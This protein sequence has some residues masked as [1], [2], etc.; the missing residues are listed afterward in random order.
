MLSLKLLLVPV[1]NGNNT[2]KM[3]GT[4]ALATLHTIMLAL[5]SEVSCMIEVQ[6]ASEQSERDTC[7]S[8]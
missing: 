3:A 4:K 1:A 5:L 7:R 6:L 8:K 2:I